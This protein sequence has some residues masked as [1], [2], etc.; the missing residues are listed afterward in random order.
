MLLFNFVNYVFLSLCLCILISMFMYSNCYVCPVLCV[1]SIVLFYVLCVNVYCTVL[2]CTV[3]YCTALYCTVLYCTALHCTAATG[4][5]IA[6]NK[7]VV[8][9]NP[10]SITGLS[11]YLSI[12]PSFCLSVCP[13]FFNSCRRL[14]ETKRHSSLFLH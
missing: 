11:V 14:P 4:C 9:R 12:Y 3:L 2:Y 1:C 10:I 5:P 8:Y 6:V 7:Y 13:V